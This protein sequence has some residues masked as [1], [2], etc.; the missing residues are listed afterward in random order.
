[1]TNFN[2]NE[3]TTSIRM[4]GWMGYGPTDNGTPSRTLQNGETYE[5]PQNEADWLVGAGLAVRV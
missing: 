1:M 3:P 4:I 5:I 2:T